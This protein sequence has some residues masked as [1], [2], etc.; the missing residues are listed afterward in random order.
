[1][2]YKPY[3]IEASLSGTRETPILRYGIAGI[4]GR[5]GKIFVHAPSKLYFPGPTKRKTIMVQNI[6]IAREYWM[7]LC[8]YSRKVEANATTIVNA[9]NA[10]AG[11]NRNPT[12]IN[13]PPTNSAKAASNPQIFGIKRIPMLAI[14]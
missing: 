2:P 3:I 6:S 13:I 12:M 5:S 9:I 8:G 14:A 1:M 4:G 7:K 10:A 11:L